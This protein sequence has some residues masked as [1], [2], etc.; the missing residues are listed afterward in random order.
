MTKK[1]IE[2]GLPYSTSCA[3]DF[4]LLPKPLDT[5]EK[6]RAKFGTSIKDIESSY[7]EDFATLGRIFLRASFSKNPSTARKEKE[8]LASR[9]RLTDAW[10]ALNKKLKID[11]WR[12]T[13]PEHKAWVINYHAEYT[14]QLEVL[15]GKSF[16]GQGL[17]KPGTQIEVEGKL[18]LIGDINTNRGTCDDCSAFDPEAIV[19]RYRVLVDLAD[20]NPTE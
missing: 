9:A 6:E 15:L 1:W 12:S 10:H 20:D 2:C 17:D 19:T 11:Q 14:K 16:K 3:V 18:Y 8:Q 4:D 13:L 7:S 5:S